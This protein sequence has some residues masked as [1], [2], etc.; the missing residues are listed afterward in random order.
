LRAA[1]SIERE[2]G[3]TKELHCRDVGPDCDA[4]VTAENEEEILAQVAEHSKSVH[5]MS[6]EQVKD[7]LFVAHVRE[8]IHEQAR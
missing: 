3:M 4:V 5:G 7:P 6:E 1:I 2:A 8:Q